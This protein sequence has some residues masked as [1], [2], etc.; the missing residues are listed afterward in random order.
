[1]SRSL[2]K[3]PTKFFSVVGAAYVPERHADSHDRH[4]APRS[5]RT[6]ETSFAVSLT[7][8]FTLIAAISIFAGEISV[9]ASVGLTNEVMAAVVE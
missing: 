2:E 4:V 3:D 7:V 9:L 1:M 8:L 6:A 5:A